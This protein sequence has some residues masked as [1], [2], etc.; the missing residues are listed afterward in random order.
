MALDHVR[1][2]FHVGAMSFQADDLTK[3]TVAIFFTRWVTHFCAPVFML[4]TGMGAYLWG[5]KPGRTK[6]DLTRC[7]VSRGAWLIF[8]EFTVLRLGYFLSLT[9]SPWL[10]TILWAI[11]WSMIALG[12][13]IHIPLNVLAPLS[14]SV[15][16]LHNAADSVTS[17]VFGPLAPLWKFLHEPGA[18]IAGKTVFFVGYPVVP[19]LFVMSAGYCLGHLF[20]QDEGTRRRWLMG[21]GAGMTIGFLVLR[22]LNVYGD[23]RPW[24]SDIPGMTVL[25]FLRTLK[26]PP[27]LLFLLM[28]LGPALLLL[29]WY[30]RLDWQPKNPLLIIGRVPLFFF[31]THFW[32][33][34]L[35]EF[36][37]AF[38]RYGEVGFLLG[39]LP[40][41]GGPAA[42]Y[43][44]GFGY[45]LPETYAIWLLVL[46]LCYPLCRWFAS[47]KERRSDWWLGYL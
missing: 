41:M 5:S 29:S 39:P 10:L 23:P 31:V 46:A 3:T 38:I 33:A 25:S 14:V 30:D 8:L 35:L 44:T 20:Q 17:G 32:L 13:L 19:W 18:I 9:S 16:A 2:F 47:V 36:P 21:L 12:L 45:S 42:A 7:L 27:S 37:L 43:P 28:T 6:A 4:T 22:A 11:G 26:Y 40:S 1:D 15:I 34:H 24:S